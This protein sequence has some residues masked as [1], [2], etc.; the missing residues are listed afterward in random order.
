MVDGAGTG[1]VDFGGRAEGAPFPDSWIHGVPPRAPREHR[2]AEPP[3]QVHR[4]D[5]HTF[6]LRQS[7]T[8]TWEAPFLYLLMGNERALLLDTGD[9]ADPGRMPLRATVD[10]LVAEW[11]GRHPRERYPLVV[12][13]T[14]GHGDHVGGDG[15]FADRPDTIVVGRDVASVREHFGF[16]DW[17]QQIVPYD[18]G[19][20]VLAVTGSPGHHEAAI[21][22]HDPWTGWLLTGDTVYPG[23]LYV[24]DAP[25]FTASLEALV[26]LADR[27]WVS[28]VMGCH[29]EMTRTPG[30]DYP[31]GTTY[32]PDEA[33]L[34]MTLEQLRAVRDA[35]REV[36]SRP[37][38]HVRDD[39]IIFNGPCRA[40]MLRQ[41]LR[42][43]ALYLPARTPSPGS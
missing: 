22:I 28:A 20:R 13:H 8:V 34:P 41:A 35:A 18:L 33:P 21:T 17:P 12:A 7:K 3:L 23:R 19:G 37:G 38:A 16:T 1:W 24:R 15:Q 43:A 5:E 36:E 11:L 4:H 26:D 42:R 30:L 27:R 39:V 2:E 25:A 31:I 32:Q 29:L 6:V 9:V 40:A 10:R 14:H